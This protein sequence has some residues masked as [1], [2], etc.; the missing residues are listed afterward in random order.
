MS[1]MN[2]KEVFDN[3]ALLSSITL[4]SRSLPLRE[5]YYY[6]CME[7]LKCCEISEEVEI[8]LIFESLI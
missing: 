4:H 3:T 1:Q 8:L 7:E 2:P 5:N 6:F